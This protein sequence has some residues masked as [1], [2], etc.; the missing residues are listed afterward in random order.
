VG[1]GL[2]LPFVVRK[3]GLDVEGRHE[4]A[5]AKDREIRARVAGVE[6]ALS[7]LGAIGPDGIAPGTLRVLRNRFRDRRDTLISALKRVDSLYGDSLAVQLRLIGA[8]RKKIA[9]LYAQDA[10]TD[11]ARRRIERELDLED[12]RV[13]HA[14]DGALPFKIDD[15]LP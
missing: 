9:E 3:L 14:H 2:T 5:I 11:E 8:E 13:R 4:Q 7:D 15:P 6:A 10:L 1:Q 12:A